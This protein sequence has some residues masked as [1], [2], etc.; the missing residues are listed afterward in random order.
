MTGRSWGTANRSWAWI[1]TRP[2]T[3]LRLKGKAD[4]ERTLAYIKN[5]LKADAVGIAW[6]FYTAGL[7]WDAS[8]EATGATLSA[9][10]VGILT[11]IATQDHLLVEYRPLIPA[12]P[13]RRITGKG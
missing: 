7:D 9:R 12:C 4:G 3:T 8:V 6:N 2:G 10:D 5:V 13:V 11:K 1:F